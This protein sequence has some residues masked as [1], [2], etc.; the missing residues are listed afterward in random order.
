[1][2]RQFGALRGLAMALVVLHHSIDFSRSIHEF[3]YP[4]PEGWLQYL[5]LVLHRLGFLAVPTFLFISGAFFSYAARG[6]TPPKLSWKVVW[7]GL[8]HLLWPYLIWSVLFYIVIFVL[9]NDI[10]SPLGYL[11][12]LIVGYPFHF[13]PIIV[14]YYL[15]SP[16]LV[17]FS[18]RF[19]TVLILG[20]GLYQLLLIS[21]LYPETLGLSTPPDWM[22]FLVPPVLS[23]QMAVWGIYFPLGLVYSINTKQMLPW[24]QKFRWIFLITTAIF[25]LFSI[26][27]SLSIVD[28]YASGYIFPLAFI[29][30]IPTIKRNSI[31]AVRQLEEIGKRSYGLYLSHL[32]VLTFVL[33]AIRSFIPWLLNY[34]FLLFPLL[35]AAGLGIPMAV[36]SRLARLPATR[37][38]YRYVFG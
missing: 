21:I 16:I 14:F 13:I 10:Y 24:L 18:E 19:G 26:L 28:F 32:I 30:F 29:L 36:M 6:S 27:T 37:S 17:K 15:V 25:F 5:M 23:T 20:V 2:N 8:K 4:L 33:L 34:Q 22:R 31:P 11:K 38:V 1:M 35:F 3:G 9:N 12:N 7:T